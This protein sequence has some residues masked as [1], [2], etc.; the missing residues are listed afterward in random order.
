MADSIQPLEYYAGLVDAIGRVN[1]EITSSN[2]RAIGYDENVKIV[3]RVGQ[4]EYTDALLGKFFEKNGIRY[5]FKREGTP[6]RYM[7]IEHNNSF[8]NFHALLGDHLIQLGRDLSFL[9]D[10]YLPARKSNKLISKKG[11]FRFVK[12]IE[13]LQP[14]RTENK[15]T[16]YSVPYFAREFDLEPA[17]VSRLDIPSISYPENISKKYLGGFFDGRGSFSI[18]VSENDTY[19]VGFVCSPQI[20]VTRNRINPILES[21]ISDYFENNGIQANINTRDDQMFILNISSIENISELLKHMLDELLLQHEV[22][23]YFLQKIIPRFKRNDHHTKQGLYEI[24]KMAEPVFQ[25]PTQ[26]RQYNSDYFEDLWKNEI[27]IRDRKSIAEDPFGKVPKPPEPE[28]YLPAIEAKTTRRQ[29]DSEFRQQVLDR[30]NYKCVVT[31]LGRVGLI[32]VCHI[33]PWAKSQELGADPEN[34]LVLNPLY[35]EA[36]DRGLFLIDTDY[37]FRTAPGIND[38]YL[39]KQLGNYD[40]KLVEF[41]DDAQPKQEYLKRRNREVDW[42]S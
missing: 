15:N 32:E 20:R 11:H 13:D 29:V 10:S 39:N 7:A 41:P 35:H 37:V 16:K 26:N 24:V 42:W 3:L 12:A 18:N 31:N 4:D 30:Y 2:S 1:F 28:T 36:Y 27:K 5:S 8:Q 21:L 25:K 19:E 9:V 6:G 40:G 38:V 34:A 14:N 17:S 23:Y 22:A 33:V